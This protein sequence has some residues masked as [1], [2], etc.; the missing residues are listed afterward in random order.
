[1]KTNNWSVSRKYFVLTFLSFI[2]FIA[3]AC[4]AAFSFNYKIFIGSITYFLLTYIALK[5]LSSLKPLTIYSLI[6]LPIIIAILYFNLYHYKSAAISAPSNIFLL[7]SACL[8]F[9]F[10]KYKNWLSP[11]LL[12]VLLAAWQYKGNRLFMNYLNY[13]QLSGQVSER[14]PLTNLYNDA[15]AIEYPKIFKTVILDFWNSKCGPCFQ[16]FPYI[17][18]IH[19]KIDTSKFELR[20][21]NIPVLNEKKEDNHNLL[22]RFDYSFNQ[23]FADNS[24]IIDSFKI[25]VFPTTIVLQNNRI[26]YRGDFKEALRFLDI[27]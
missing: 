27:E 5:R 11:L 9:L 4:L 8:G 24:S 10:Y 21:V 26:T 13:G 3:V 25:T 23:L 6:I 12:I 1:M 17:E 15:G 7:A 20:V 2:L 22:D 18:R 14:I 16:S 19:R